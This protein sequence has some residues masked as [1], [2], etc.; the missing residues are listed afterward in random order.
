MLRLFKPTMS[1]G[2][3][4]QTSQTAQQAPTFNAGAIRSVFNQAGQPLLAI[5]EGILFV[6]SE[7]SYSQAH[8]HWHAFCAKLQ[9][10]PATKAHMPKRSC[11]NNVRTVPPML[12]TDVPTLANV[13][14][15]L[16][17][18][19]P[20]HLCECAAALYTHYNMES[21][22]GFV[23]E[24]IV[25]SASRKVSQNEQQ[26]L[27]AAVPSQSVDLAPPTTVSAIVPQTQPGNAI[28]ASQPANVSVALAATMPQN[29]VAQ[30][31]RVFQNNTFCLRALHDV[32]GE[33]WFKGNEVAA[34]LGY[35]DH[36]KAIRTHVH[37]D[38]RCKLQNLHISRGGELPPL[39]KYEQEATWIN[40]PGALQLLTSSQ[41]ELG[42]ECRL[43][44]TGDVVPQL[45]RT[46]TYTIQPQLPTTSHDELQALQF[47]HLAAQAAAERQHEALLR[48]QAKLQRIELAV[49]AKQAAQEL[50]LNTN[51][52]L[53]VAAQLAIDAAALPPNLSDE[54][55]TDAGEYLRMRGHSESEVRSLQVT[56]GLMLKKHYQQVHGVTPPGHFHAEFGGVV[57]TPYSY[58]RQADRELLN[59][60]YQ[61]LTLTDTYRKQVPNELLALN[62]VA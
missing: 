11:D 38:R 35:E 30:I 31:G 43:W 9:L 44:F 34:A 12:A 49:K 45:L 10:P 22:P 3:Q 29:A 42:E 57:K 15:S 1:F 5:L 51:Q 23:Y 58:N 7:W 48:V 36:N 4:S 52:A 40:L 53:D 33:L 20:Q 21:P 14:M 59:G 56:F 39:T 19:C 37:V 60:T 62:S 8:A 50:G 54:G 32:N 13:F 17:E 46:G 6:K 61:M 55:F 24:P 27:A 18:S 26:T 2:Q 41:T 25:A 47:E 28:I 16:P